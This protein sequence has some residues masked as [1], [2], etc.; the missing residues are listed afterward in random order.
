VF[1]DPFQGVWWKNPGFDPNSDPSLR[2][3]NNGLTLAEAWR[4]SQYYAANGMTNGQPAYAAW[5][6][7]TYP[8][9]NGEPLNEWVLSSRG[10]Y[11]QGNSDW[12]DY[13]RPAIVIFGSLVA[14]GLAAEALGASASAGV[15]GG[16][17]VAEAVVLEEVGAGTALSA[18]AGAGVT[19]AEAGLVAEASS[20][21][22]L[23]SIGGISAAD[24]L[25]AGLMELLPEDLAETTLGEAAESAVRDAVSDAIARERQREANDLVSPSYPPVGQSLMDATVFGFSVPVLMFTVSALILM[26][27]ISHFRR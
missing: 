24:I 14:G 12:V 2:D 10:Y 3:R 25:P 15:A 21:G 19:A 27:S 20:G 16:E 5:E 22:L 17:G 11:L 9:Q 8:D 7:N 6:W 4:A 26:F 13:W 23:S 18:E 1:L